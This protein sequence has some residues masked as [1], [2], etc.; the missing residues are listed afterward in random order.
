MQTNVAAPP[1]GSLI[2]VALHDAIK[3]EVIR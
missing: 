2:A 3:L 1:I